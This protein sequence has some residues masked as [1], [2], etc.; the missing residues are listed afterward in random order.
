MAKTSQR[1]GGWTVMLN[2]QNAVTPRESVALQLTG[3]WPTAKVLP[4]AGAQP[5]VTGAVPPVLV[6]SV[7]VSSAFP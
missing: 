5:T 4:D 3:V 2:E 6:G 7:S 1:G